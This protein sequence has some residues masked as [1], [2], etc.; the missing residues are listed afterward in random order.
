MAPNSC[1]PIAMEGRNKESRPT[2][3]REDCQRAGDYLPS[4]CCASSA[5]FREHFRPRAAY[6][7]I[8]LKTCKIQTIMSKQQTK[9]THPNTHHA[10]TAQLLHLQT[11]PLTA[12]HQTTSWVSA[13]YC[14]LRP[15]L[16]SLLIVTR[17]YRYSGAAW[18]FTFGT[19]A[20]LSFATMFMAKDRYFS[21][22]SWSSSGAE[23]SKKSCVCYLITP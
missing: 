2:N 5:N 7:T 23:G 10:R 11:T 9:K 21:F 1:S 13:A 19:S 22:F 18:T 8:P 6:S 12:P 20:G 16:P 17:P 3:R 4:H 14:H 15:S